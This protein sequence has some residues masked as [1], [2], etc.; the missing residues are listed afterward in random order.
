MDAYRRGA[1]GGLNGL[2]GKNATLTAAIDGM[3]PIQPSPSR[4][5]DL[6]GFS[7]QAYQRGG[8]VVIAY[9]GTDDGSAG[10][11]T[12]GLDKTHGYGIGNGGT[13]A[14]QGAAAI[15]FYRSIQ[16]QV[17]GANNIAVTGHRRREPLNNL[18]IMAHLSH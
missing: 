13:D 10:V 2:I 17:S 16:Q 15:D 4:E 11:F 1:D 8:E 14:A 9:R 6:I 3:V 5:N 12:S 18:A 7:A